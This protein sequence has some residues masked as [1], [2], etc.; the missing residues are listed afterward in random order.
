MVSYDAYASTVAD[1]PLVWHRI[2]GPATGGASGGGQ[3]DPSYVHLLPILG[4]LV[5][6]A[7]RD[8][9]FVSSVAEFISV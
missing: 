5:M 6:S 9:T 8:S 1:A 2:S 7:S 4:R 3:T